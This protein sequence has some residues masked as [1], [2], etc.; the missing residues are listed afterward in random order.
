MNFP[1]APRRQRGIA[2]LLII[3]LLCAAISVT[4]MGA[5]YA[6]R[7]T[8]QRQ[9]TV[10]AA[11]S[12]QGAAWRGVETVRL[13]LTQAGLPTLTEWCNNDTCAAGDQV[14]DKTIGDL[15]TI[16]VPDARLVRIRRPDP[17]KDIY[18]V[19]AQ[20]TGQAGSGDS[21]TQSTVEVVYEV[22]NVTTGGGST[23]G[24]GE[25]APLNAVITFNHNLNLSGSI[26]VNKPA[27]T[28][29]Q[30]NVKGDLTTGG[31][32]ITGVDTI[33]STG[34]IQISS[35]STFG[36]LAA[37]GDIKFDGSVTATRA[38]N[39]R[40][41]ICISGGANAANAQVRANGSVVANGGVVLGDVSAIGTSQRGSETA[42]CTTHA[43]RPGTDQDGKVFAVDLKD[44][45]SARTVA[46]TGSVRI[47]SGSITGTEG[48]RATGHLVDTNWGGTECGQVGLSVSAANPA[49]TG[50]VSTVAGLQ[51]PI[52]PVSPV[53]L[54]QSS[55]NAYDVEA[56][57]HYVFKINANGYKIVT[58]RGINGI[59]DDTYFIGDY[60]NTAE[61]GW[62]RGYKDFLC[63][64]LATGS[65]STAPR[66]QAPVLDP[67]GTPCVGYST[68]NNCIAYDALSRTWTLS[69]TSFAPGIAWFEGNL[70]LSNGIYYN[71]FVATGNISTAG[72]LTVYAL[73]YAGY[74]GKRGSTTYAPTGICVNSHFPGRYPTDYCG[75][76]GS[77]FAP[78]GDS[79]M[80][81]YA[82]LAGS[83]DV[84]DHYVGGMIVLGSSN[85]IFG[86]LLAGDLYRSGGSTTVHGSITA[87]SLGVGEHAAGGSTTI[88]LRDLPEG[89]VPIIDPCKLNGTCATAP[90]GTTE[91]K[92]AVHWTRYL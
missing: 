66:C 72:G 81:N 3:L 56:A 91:F 35:G 54:N 4:A 49:V 17:A 92:A 9:M 28:E 70:T 42:K 40:G 16:G 24:S 76:D 31:N 25:P 78:P 53:N 61:T 47:N 62:S 7:G 89:F 44:N 20:V 58:V 90:T 68:Y 41:D 11:T 67:P 60:D 36:T 39:A 32:T 63:K 2:T 12:A 6:L 48:L 59:A 15:E 86:S 52:A 45:S 83:Y 75:T 10:H 73:N 26:T 21:L 50:C 43:D 88:D 65:T 74:N 87:L 69:G 55:F 1:A 84:N 71:T 34:S 80:G 13:A 51:V 5:A 33:W 22:G 19:T 79:V 30:I 27:G 29:Y 18:L 82:L 37:N 14:L 64:Q 77:A 85:N 57:A 8:Q 38:V 23:P 46:A